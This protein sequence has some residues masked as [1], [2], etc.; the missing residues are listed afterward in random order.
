MITLQLGG[1]G[2]DAWAKPSAYHDAS[3]AQFG[4]VPGVRWDRID[5]CYRGDAISIGLIAAKLEAAKVAVVKGW[6]LTKAPNSLITVS[7]GWMH[8]SLRDYQKDGVSWLRGTLAR[9]GAALLADDMGIGK[10][11]QTIAALEGTG[12]TLVLAPAI[13]VPHWSG[14]LR[15]WLRNL[16]E[17]QNWLVTSPDK[18]MRAWSKKD[19]LFYD[20][21]FKNVV[22]DEI[23][24]YANPKAKR[25]K[26]VIALIDSHASRP[27]VVGLTGTPISTKVFDLWSVLNIL[28]PG[29]FGNAFLFQK[30]YCDGQF[31]ELPGVEKPIWIAKGQSNLEELHLR[32]APL[33]L[34]RTKAQV[35]IELPGLTRDIR[36]LEL[37]AS[38]ARKSLKDASKDI[39]RG[40]FNG[41]NLHSLLNG[42]EEFKIDAA[43]ELAR[44]LLDAGS[45][46]LILTRTKATAKAIAFELRCPV[47]DGDTYA[48]K[49]REVLLSGDG[50]AVSTMFAVTTGI[51]LIEFDS[52]IFVG[53]D[54]VPATMLQ[55]EARV[56]RFGQTRP[57]T[58][59]YLV[60]LGTVDEVIRERVIDRLDLLATVT[61]AKG[62]EAELSQSFAGGSD[63]DLLGQLVNDIQSRL[64]LKKKEQSK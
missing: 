37:P 30:R 23:H 34:R 14:Q 33:M 47:A 29:R 7:A 20:R 60:G 3:K 21:P 58:A 17:T 62:D 31:E 35:A 13:A 39:Q 9:E 19:P 27:N 28:W 24:Y 44:D 56:W 57:V 54:W 45:R 5:E 36:E 38:A 41:D 42:V 46:P 12:P 40:E 4:A 10:T 18:F 43:C 2:R 49:R 59:Y 1:S 6:D 25:T 55:A 53:P 11:P 26:A 52:V 61:G 22:L 51:D 63:D 16:E 50:P 64:K 32:L 8:P 48:S 15:K